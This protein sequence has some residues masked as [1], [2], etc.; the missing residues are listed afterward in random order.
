MKENLNEIYDKLITGQIKSEEAV[1]IIQSSDI[2]KLIS[3]YINK[4][5][6]NKLVPYSEQ[7]IQNIMMLVKISQFIYNDIGVDAIVPDSDYDS[8][9]QILLSNGGADITSAPISPNSGPIGYH[10]YPSLRG[11]LSK[12][13]YLTKD[14]TRTNPSRKYLDE[15]KSSMENDIFNKSGKRI[16]L[17]EEEIYVFPKFDGISV[18]F[19][20][21]ENGTMTKALTRGYTATNEAMDITQHFKYRHD[22]N[23]PMRFSN[24]PYGI[25]TEVMMQTKDLDKFNKKYNKDYKNTRSVVAAI[26]NSDEYNEEKSRFLHVVPLR[27]GN[28]DTQ[29]LSS[30]AF[31]DYPYIRCRLKDREMIRKFALEHRFVNGGLRCDGAVIYIINPDIQDI[32]G[33][34]NDK[35]KFE[36]AYKFTEES[37]MT[38]LLDITF[39]MGLFGRIAPVAHVKPVKLKGNTIENVSLGSVGRFNQLQLRKGDKVKIL[40]DI[41][42]YLCFDGDC[43]HNLDNE[44]IELPDVCPECGEKLEYSLSDDEFNITIASCVNSDCPCIIKGKILNYLNKMDIAGISYGIIDKLYNEGFV[45]DIPDLYKIK[46]HA[47]EIASLDGFGTKSVRTW[48]DVLDPKTPVTDYTV[49]GALGIEG[50]SKKTFQ[51]IFNELDINELMD[52]VDN[53]RMSEL[54]QIPHIKEKTAEKLINGISSNKKLI[55]FLMK[56]LNIIDTKGIMSNNSKFT[57]CFTKINDKDKKEMEPMIKNMMGE[58][59]DNITKHTTFLITPSDETSSSK[60]SKAKKYNIPI[61]TMDRFTPEIIKEYL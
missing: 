47:K 32:L 61:I 9:Y 26:I 49:F 23:E 27:I 52:I 6:I 7:D 3:I 20:F 42:P 29:E 40:Y 53:K 16:N 50:L 51:K 59:V 14:E 39:N 28:K 24:R 18:I 46:K 54:I 4:N 17:D 22:I 38:E 21:D 11:T 12:V 15:W 34:E 44:I 2:R 33:R 1:E 36:V 5:S 57:V 19:E 43:E 30:R 8:L 25:K 58:I 13:Y 60:V 45:K 37:A 35:N 48:I 55:T 10:E 31:M 56:K 41:I